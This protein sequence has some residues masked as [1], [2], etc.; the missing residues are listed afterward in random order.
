VNAKA[1]CLLLKALGGSEKSR[2]ATAG[3]RNDVPLPSRTLVV[4]LDTGRLRHRW[5]PET[6][7]TRCRWDAVLA[8]WC[9][10]L[11]SCTRA[12]A[13]S[14]RF[15]SP[16]GSDQGCWAATD[17]VRWTPACLLGSQAD[18]QDRCFLPF[19]HCVAC[20]CR[21]ILNRQNTSDFVF[22]RF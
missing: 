15:C 22:F 12:A 14:P 13:S 3:T 9:L 16:P 21:G 10:G 20:H 2:F 7:L 1:L 17:L 8:G 4:A 11:Q 5:H 18:H 19:E 6:D